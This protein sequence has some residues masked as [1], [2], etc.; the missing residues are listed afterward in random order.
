MG[1]GLDI[2]VD[3]D[4]GEEGGDEGGQRGDEDADEDDEQH[5]LVVVPHEGG[6]AQ[7]HVTLHLADFL[8]AC[9]SSLSLWSKRLSHTSQFLNE[10]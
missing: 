7:Q 10:E 4:L 8:K 3:E 9:L 2:V 1:E 5:P 6:H